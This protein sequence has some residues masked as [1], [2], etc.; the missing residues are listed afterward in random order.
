[1]ERRSRIRLA[2]LFIK[3]TEYED[4][5]EATISGTKDGG[6]ITELGPKTRSKG[7]FCAAV[8]RLLKKKAFASSLEP[9]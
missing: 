4:L 1:M 2:A 6:I 8:K 9:T 7:I 3:P 5:A